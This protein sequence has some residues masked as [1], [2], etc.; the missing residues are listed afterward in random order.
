M[1]RRPPWSQACGL[2]GS[3]EVQSSSNPF[4]IALAFLGVLALVIAVRDSSHD[5]AERATIRPV[6]SATKDVLPPPPIHATQASPDT[7]QECSYENYLYPEWPKGFNVSV[8]AAFILGAFTVWSL[9]LRGWLRVAHCCL[10][11]SRPLRDPEAKAFPGCVV[12]HDWPFL[13]LPSLSL[14]SSAHGMIARVL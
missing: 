10:E 11:S 5:V 8:Q 3:P 2:L 4:V 7:K 6:Y 1:P 9:Q 13:L 12:V 14:T